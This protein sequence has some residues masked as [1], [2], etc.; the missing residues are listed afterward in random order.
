[1]TNPNPSRPPALAATFVAA[2]P[3][4]FEKPGLKRHV[5]VWSLWALGVGA[6]I[7]GYFS[8]WN[9]GLAVGGW[10]ACWWLPRSWR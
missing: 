1:M 10:G 6:V 5:G 9:L 4:Y 7:S 2:A 8:R 3:G